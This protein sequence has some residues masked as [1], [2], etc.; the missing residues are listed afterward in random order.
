[1][2]STEMFHSETMPHFLERGDMASTGT[3]HMGIKDQEKIVQFLH[4]LIEIL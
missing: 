1:M 3:E 4:K 2:V